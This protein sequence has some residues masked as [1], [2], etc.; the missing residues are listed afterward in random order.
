VTTDRSTPRPPTQDTVR[1][2]ANVDQGQREYELA[3]AVLT[4][5]IAASRYS[6]A[7]DADRIIVLKRVTKLVARSVA[8]RARNIATK[9]RTAAASVWRIKEWPREQKETD[10]VTIGKTTHRA[11]GNRDCPLRV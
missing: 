1:A 10:D 4:L 9:H 5:L 7:S 11:A 8:E 2:D 6:G 3:D